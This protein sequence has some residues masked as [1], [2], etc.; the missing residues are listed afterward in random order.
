[1][2]DYTNRVANTDKI[3]VSFKAHFDDSP[4]RV[5]RRWVWEFKFADGGTWAT[6]NAARGMRLR[7]EMMKMG[8][9]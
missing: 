8:R 1:M 9:V 5:G 6:Y 3:P 7:N 2:N 4:N